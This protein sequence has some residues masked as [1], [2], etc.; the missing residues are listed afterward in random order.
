MGRARGYDSPI[1]M[2]RILLLLAAVA[3]LVISSSAQVFKI[4][5]GTFQIPGK[6]SGF[7][8]GILMIRQKDPGGA[9]VEYPK[10]KETIEDLKKRLGAYIVPMF[11]HDTKPS[12]D[13]GTPPLLLPKITSVPSHKGDL[14]DSGEM[15]LY[16][17]EKGEVQILFYGRS[18]SD[19]PYVYGYFAYHPLP[20][21][22]NPKEWADERGN[23]VKFLDQFWKTI[24]P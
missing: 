24:S 22:G 9:F 6:D 19:K 18:A 1:D 14:G 11:L 15:Y 5:E 8:H 21:K 12:K 20:A 13:A 10:E 4:P 16:S 17:T 7:D 2:K 23:G 3:A